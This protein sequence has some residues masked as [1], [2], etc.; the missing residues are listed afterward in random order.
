MSR[1][2]SEVRS[3]KVRSSSV[4]SSGIGSEDG[5]IRKPSRSN[6]VVECRRRGLGI[7]EPVVDNA[8]SIFLLTIKNAGK[9]F[10]ESKPWPSKKDLY[11]S[12]TSINKIDVI[13]MSEEAENTLYR[14]YH[15]L[16]RTYEE[17]VVS[18]AKTSKS[19]SVYVI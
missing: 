18:D 11:D 2:S 6:S 3:S 19:K 1:S 8:K 12:A 10:E 16:L 13:L 17:K 4:A 5:T 7:T 9:Q 14:H 15:I